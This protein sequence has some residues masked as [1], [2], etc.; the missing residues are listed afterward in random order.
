MYRNTSLP[1]KFFPKNLLLSFIILFWLLTFLYIFFIPPLSIPNIFGLFGLLFM[2]V[3]L[4]VKMLTQKTKLSLWLA[5]FILAWPLLSLT[6]LLT[7]QNICL[8]IAMF[9]SLFLLFSSKHTP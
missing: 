4:S 1:K 9:A 2:A 3:F 6:R 7:L 8:T 5:F